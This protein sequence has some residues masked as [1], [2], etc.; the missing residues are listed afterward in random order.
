M[1]D[2]AQSSITIASDKAT[3]MNVIADFAAYPDWAGFIK[4]AEV[5][6]DGPDGRA[7]Q[8][9]FVLDAGVI[10]DDYVLEYVWDDDTEVK[11]RLVKGSV[12][13]DMDGTYSLADAGDGGGT[14]VTYRL[15]VDLKI[16]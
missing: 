5:V 16:P 9:R 4:S 1:V 14:E 11:W 10:K 8:V 2:Q 15:A 12:L 3:I 6:E 7:K 13:K